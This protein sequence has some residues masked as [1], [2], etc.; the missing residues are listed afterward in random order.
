VTPER[1]TQTEAILAS[2]EF[3]TLPPP[4]AD[5]YAGW[6]V[7]NDSSGDSLHVP[8]G[9]PGAAVDYRPGKTPRPRLLFIMSSL[10]LQGLA[11]TLDARI[12][13]P[14]PPDQPF[15]TEAVGN[16]PDDGVLLF[17]VEEGRKGE[18]S[19]ETNF[20]P[21]ARDWPNRDDF[22]SAEIFTEPAPE[23]RWVSTGGSFR[24]YRF[25]VWIGRGPRASERDFELALKSAASL[26]VS[27][28]WR[29]AYDDCPDEDE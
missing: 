27:S 15:P 25:S 12:D 7:V 16:L 2:L 4:P 13:E 11:K 9:W 24:G 22:E 18:W 23:L 19:L 1:L 6:P 14:P 3:D 5:P 8:P 20:A 28:C 21:I 17:V 10:P 29:D 26:A